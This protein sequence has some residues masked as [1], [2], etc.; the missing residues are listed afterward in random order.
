ML[1]S[2]EEITRL[3]ND[4]GMNKLDFRDQRKLIFDYQKIDKKLRLRLNEVFYHITWE[5]KD[6]E[7]FKYYDNLED[8]ENLITRFQETMKT[9]VNDNEYKRQLKDV[10]ILSDEQRI[11]LLVSCTYLL[12]YKW[13]FPDRNKQI[14]ALM[15]QHEIYLLTD[16]K[17]FENLHLKYLGKLAQEIEISLAE[18]FIQNKIPKAYQTK[19]EQVKTYKILRA[20]D[21]FKTKRLDLELLKNQIA[22]LLVRHGSILNNNVVDYNLKD[23]LMYSPVSNAL[24]NKKFIEKFMD[25]LNSSDIR[26]KHLVE[27]YY[28]IM[29]S[30]SEA[31]I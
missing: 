21:S 5:S 1:L 12:K 14:L 7:H 24:E 26:A 8:F 2:R 29:S 11:E 31:L 6:E 10:L 13:S 28:L 20:L 18:Y 27:I 22:L 23:F 25:E 16:H 3:V 15:K 19:L 4:F 30:L 9:D 17:T